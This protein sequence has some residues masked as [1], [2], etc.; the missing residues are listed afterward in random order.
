MS[1][2]Q[3][4]E[5]TLTLGGEE[6]EEPKEEVKEEV[7]T[8]DLL[9]VEDTKLTPAEKKMVTDF[10]KKIDVTETNTILEYG[11]S[12][13]RKI[14]DFSETALKNVRTK[15]LGDVGDMLSE[16]IGELRGFEIEEK[17]S[18]GFLGFFKKQANK[19][20]NLKTKYDKAAVNVDKITKALE[21]HQITLMKDIALLDQLYDKNLLNFKELSMY[22]L[23]GKKRLEEVKNKDLVAL[24]N[25]AQESKLPEDAQAASD[26]ENAI[27]RFEKKLHDLELTR[28]ISIQM[29]PQIR[30]V[31]NND[32]Q[33]VEKIQSTLINTIPLWKSQ[34]LIAMG[35][36]HSKEAIK[37]Q[38]EV[39][40]MTNKMLNQNAE[41]LKTAT[42]DTARESERAIVD[43]ETL[44]NTNA[45]LIETLDEVK[46]VQEEGRSKRA[47]AQIELRKIETELNDK[48]TN[49][50]DNLKKES[51][52]ND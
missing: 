51:T 17:E 10:A 47:Q 44:R 39:T 3:T 43:I 30:L 22:I 34:M 50:S 21:E 14:A 52:K 6:N 37:A 45:R 49:L 29:A 46:R 11:S 36:S 8:E 18:N 31:Q 9:S 13:Q 20:S 38:N 25:K 48:L 24:R 23:A 26:L 41:L 35:I 7:K 19:V 28:V 32:T 33:M 4:E 5:I 40:E 27:N 12:A 15:D 16:L 2:K 1:E 42:I